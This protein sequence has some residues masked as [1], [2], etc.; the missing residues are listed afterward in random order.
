MRF[1]KGK[2][3]YM[4]RNCKFFIFNDVINKSEINRKK[5]VLVTRQILI[6]GPDNMF[7]IG[8]EM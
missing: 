1:G 4:K 5:K 6:E 3:E 7:L 2:V 8:L